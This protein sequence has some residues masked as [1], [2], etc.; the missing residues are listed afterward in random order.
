MKKPYLILCLVLLVSV[1][2]AQVPK[3]V[4][5]ETKPGVSL[6]VNV[7]QW[8][9][10]QQQMEV[11]QRFKNTPYALSFQVFG[12]QLNRRMVH[13][14][15]LD[16]DTLH[17]VSS[18]GFGIGI[19]RYEQA[20]SE[21]FFS[22]LSVFYKDVTKTYSRQEAESKLNFYWPFS[23]PT[24]TYLRA[25]DRLTGFGLELLGGY[26]YLNGYFFIEAQGGVVARFLEPQGNY[27]GALSPWRFRPYTNTSG[28]NP[29]LSVRMGVQL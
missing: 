1:S 29:M 6:A 17:G 26:R 20:K 5:E 25:S 18:L 10:G 16:L 19:R 8:Y 28:L 21:G 15:G 11:E 12:G 4:S 22:Q 3:A 7:S 24:I 27:L 14:Q 9:V 2:V 13:A 23:S